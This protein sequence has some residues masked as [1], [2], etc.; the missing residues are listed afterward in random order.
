MSGKRRHEQN[1]TRKVK[2]GNL[3]SLSIY[4]HT[5]TYIPTLSDNSEMMILK[6]DYPDG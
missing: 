5:K 3:I 2:N 4:I 6:S 1:G